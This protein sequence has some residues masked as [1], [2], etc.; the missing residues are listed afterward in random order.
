MTEMPQYIF[1]Q[2]V[3]LVE[4]MFLSKNSFGD[5]ETIW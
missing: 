2:L 5:L 1:L 3:S 4:G